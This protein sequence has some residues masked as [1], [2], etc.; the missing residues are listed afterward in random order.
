M[1]STHAHPVASGLS[2]PVC[3]AAPPGD[4]N[5]LFVLEQHAGRIRILDRDT[6]QVRP[7]SFLE[8]DGLATG[9]EQGLL[10]LAFH[11]EFAENGFFYVNCT[12]EGGVF[13]NGVT[14]VRRYQVSG[15]PDVA[16][17]T[18]AQTVLTFDQ[19]FANH[20]GGWL[21]FGPRD[22]FLYV[23]VG[24]GG[25]AN[26]PG[27]RAQ[28]LAELFGKML[29]L[30]VNGDDFS[31]DPER[32]YRIPPDNPFSGRSGARP[33]IWAYGLR[34]P[35]RASFDRLTGD[36]YIGDVG[37]GRLE[38]IDFQP[39]D[40]PGGENYGW[41]WKEGT[42]NTGLDPVGPEPLVVPIHEYS[43]EDGIAVIGGYVY[44][45]T[46]LPELQGT[47]FFADHDGPVW[48][49]RFDG[50][51]KAE[52]RDRTEELTAA[53]AIGQI[54]SFGEDA[55][56]ELYLLSLEGSVHRIVAAP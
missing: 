22:G 35:W 40:S 3:L 2:R 52:F 4:R 16:D 23:S 31:D 6:G 54:T 38:E 27:R 47:Y 14:S 53:G 8:V 48:S 30:D 7:Q 12:L 9:N 13:G 44:R 43:H 42:R 32:N 55:D 41:R 21:G 34:N 5:R 19:P 24:D 50:R 29:R 18:S 11:P 28:N 37:Q 10:G 26:D 25:S 39:A 1:N 17:P 20:N 46:A 51:K 56:G 36:L 33:E 49:F 45:G 15:D